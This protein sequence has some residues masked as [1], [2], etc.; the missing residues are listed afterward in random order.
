[1]ASLLSS[2]TTPFAR[3]ARNPAA[4]SGT[5]PAGGLGG[6]RGPVR[7]TSPSRSRGWRSG[8]PRHTCRLEPG[9]HWD[10]LR[11]Q[12]DGVPSDLQ[13]GGLDQGEP[14]RERPVVQGVPSVG[15]GEVLRVLGEQLLL[16]LRLQAAVRRRRVRERHLIGGSGADYLFGGADLDWAVGNDYLD[17]GYGNDT[18]YGGGRHD[19]LYAFYGNDYLDG[20]SGNDTLRGRPGTTSW[21]AGPA[22]T[23]PMAGRGRTPSTASGGTLGAASG[24]STIGKGTGPR[25]NPRPAGPGLREF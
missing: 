23:K 6:T 1:M 25:A 12:R 3:D 21:S 2:L 14:E 13:R 17:G 22:W 9:H 8:P 7:K 5:A 24:I 10:E 19:T 20:G 11:G 4:P 18:L 16:L 15:T